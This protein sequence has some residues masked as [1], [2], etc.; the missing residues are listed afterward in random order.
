MGVQTFCTY[1]CIGGKGSKVSSFSNKFKIFSLIHRHRQFF[2]DP[3]HQ[4]YQER[5]LIRQQ[6][7]STRLPWLSVLWLAI[8]L[9]RTNKRKWLLKK[10]RNQAKLN[11]IAEDFYFNKFVKFTICLYSR[12]PY[13]VPIIFPNKPHTQYFLTLQSKRAREEKLS[14]YNNSA[15]SNPDS[16]KFWIIVMQI[17]SLFIHITNFLRTS[18][19]P[20]QNFCILLLPPIL[21]FSN[22]RVSTFHKVIFILNYLIIVLNYLTLIVVII[23]LKPLNHYEYYELLVNQ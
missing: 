9:A 22:N 18:T 3:Q 5:T 7:C 20:I 21:M 17:S 16:T 13:S 8:T 15:F 12:L 11:A 2:H 19:I 4:F 14:L 6:F 23:F 1:G 10:W